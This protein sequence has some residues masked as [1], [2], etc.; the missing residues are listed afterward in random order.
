[1]KLSRAATLTT[2]P[3]VAILALAGCMTPAAPEPEATKKPSASATSEPTQSASSASGDVTEPGTKVGLGEEVIYESQG[4][5]D[6]TA[7]VSAKLTEV[8]PATPEQVAFLNSQ[9]DDGELAGFDVTLIRLEMTKVSGDPI[10]FNSDSTSFAP[11]DA[12]GTKVQEV[13][14]IGW[15]ECSSES[16]S[17]EFDDGAPITQCYVAAAPA[18]GN[19]PAG[20]MYDGGFTD[21]NPFS[22]YDG[23]PILLIKD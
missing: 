7:L 21:P 8:T 16:F 14:L 22:D 10:A 1:M 5:D 19:A 20:L 12:K 13:T 2:L 4:T 18:G 23:D 11:V 6:V 3:V 17:K 9:F 15:D